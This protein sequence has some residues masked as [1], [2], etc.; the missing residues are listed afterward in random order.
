MREDCRQLPQDE[1]QREAE[2]RSGSPLSG[3]RLQH[4]P[5]GKAAPGRLMTAGGSG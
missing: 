3:C 5:D 1:I 2:D 4:V